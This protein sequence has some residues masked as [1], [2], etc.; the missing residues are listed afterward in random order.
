MNLQYRS[1]TFDAFNHADFSIPLQNLSRSNFGVVT[2]PQRRARQFQLG[3][4]FI[5]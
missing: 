4:K 2:A 3:H 1:E 5:Y